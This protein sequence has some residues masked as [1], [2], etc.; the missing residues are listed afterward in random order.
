MAYKQSNHTSLKESSKG[1]YRGGLCI[2][3]GCMNTPNQKKKKK[4]ILGGCVRMAIG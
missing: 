3:I 4:K 1:D 2:Q